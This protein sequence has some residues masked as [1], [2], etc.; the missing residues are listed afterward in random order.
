MNFQGHLLERLT[1]GILRRC[2]ARG[3]WEIHIENKGDIVKMIETDKKTKDMLGTMQF[4]KKYHKA[5]RY[6]SHYDEQKNMQG[7]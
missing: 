4:S 5:Y 1:I 2:N 7:K 3:E 6:K